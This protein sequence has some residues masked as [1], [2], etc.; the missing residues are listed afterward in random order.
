MLNDFLWGLP[1][2]GILRLSYMSSIKMTDR[3]EET[4]ANAN[5][6]SGAEYSLMDFFSFRFDCEI[7]EYHRPYSW[8][9][10][11]TKDL[12]DD[13]NEFYSSQP[14]D[15]QYFLGSIHSIDA[16]VHWTRTRFRFASSATGSAQLPARNLNRR[17]ARLER[18]A[19]LV[20]VDSLGA[21]LPNGKCPTVAPLPL[22]PPSMFHI[23]VPLVRC[24]GQD[25]IK[26]RTTVKVILTFYVVCTGLEPVTPS[27]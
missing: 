1:V 4:V 20:S 26:I 25:A 24:P 5:Q 6:I 8:E 14:E 15:K 18:F 21:L 27:M 22:L 11:Q 10:D 2:C 23:S 17:I 12:F 16:T 9:E 13:L 7:H 19:L 3:A